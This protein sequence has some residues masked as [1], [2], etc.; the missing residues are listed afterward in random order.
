MAQTP[1]ARTSANRAGPTVPESTGR[2]KASTVV[3]SYAQ[4]RC[5]RARALPI[6]VLAGFTDY[7]SKPS[8]HWRARRCLHR[9]APMLM[10]AC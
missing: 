10:G 4:W 9:A 8:A 3:R 5:A 6:A 7:T 1:A 2:K